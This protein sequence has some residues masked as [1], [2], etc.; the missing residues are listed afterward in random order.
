VELVVELDEF[1]AVRSIGDFDSGGRVAGE[2]SEL[3]R[4]G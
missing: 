3:F 1:I 4:G 2:E